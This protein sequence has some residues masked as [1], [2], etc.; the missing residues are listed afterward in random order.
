MLEAAA[1]ETWNFLVFLWSALAVL[2]DV[3]VDTKP[4]GLLAAS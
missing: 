2:Q 3:I 1:L 4:L